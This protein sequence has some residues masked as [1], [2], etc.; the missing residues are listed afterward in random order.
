MRPIL[1][2]GLSLLALTAGAREATVPCYELRT[3]TAHEGRLEALHQRFR[4]HTMALFARHGMVHVGYWV[5]RGD[6]PGRR[7]IYLLE[8]A[9][10]PAAAASWKGFLADPDW[11]AAFARSREQGPLVMK[12][13]SVFLAATDYS[14]PVQTGKTPAARLFELRTYQAAP[15]RMEA[16]HARFRDHTL[17]LFSR[18][19]MT[20]LGYF[21]TLDTPG[22]LVYLLAHRNRQAARESFAAFREDPDWQAARKASE[23][24]AGG[25]LTTRVESLLLVPVDYSPTR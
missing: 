14:P 6:N 22:T 8:H 25:S 18:H 15:G 7:L 4:D 12:V 13:E 3:Y 2:L 24:A 5:P 16:L 23:E 17:A 9:S 11:K 1:F 20:N 19:G 10:R 21:E